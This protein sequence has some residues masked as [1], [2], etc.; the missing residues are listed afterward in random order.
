M[1]I[2]TGDCKYCGGTWEVNTR[3]LTY[4]ACCDRMAE[5]LERGCEDEAYLRGVD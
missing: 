3:Y 2:N 5:E 1:A 4:L